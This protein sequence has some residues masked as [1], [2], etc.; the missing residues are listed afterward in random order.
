LDKTYS[1]LQTLGSE[2]PVDIELDREYFEKN[3]Y[4]NWSQLEQKSVV[5]PA[6]TIQQ[7]FSEPVEPPPPKRAGIVCVWL[8][9]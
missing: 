3:N 9:W 1:G 2:T 7:I 6:R 5:K 8:L 4:I